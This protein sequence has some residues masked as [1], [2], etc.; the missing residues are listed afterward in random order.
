M[1]VERDPDNLTQEFSKVDRAGRILVDT[2]RN[3]YSATFAAAY[4]VR[5][6]PGAPVSAPCTWEEIE[7]G[8]VH[9]KSFTLR[10]MA[11]RVAAVGDLW[12]DLLRKKRSLTKAIHSLHG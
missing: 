8:E 6:R 7:R 5:A 9:P 3:G 1:L 10:T 2:G 12:S 4:T 11:A